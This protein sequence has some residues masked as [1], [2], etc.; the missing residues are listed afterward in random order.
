MGEKLWIISEKLGLMLITADFLWITLL[1]LCI[2][3][4][5]TCGKAGDFMPQ[6]CGQFVGRQP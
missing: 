3:L 4:R 6:I 5:Q 2:K 1:E